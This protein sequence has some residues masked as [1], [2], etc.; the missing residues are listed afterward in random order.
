MAPTGKSTVNLPTWI[1]LD[2]AKFKKLSVTASLPGTGL[3]ATTTAE[4]VSL[5]IEPGT[6]DAQTY[7]P[8]GECAINA[9]GSIGAPYAKGK[10]DQI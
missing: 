8:S 9:Y 1:W 3:S 7:P 4:P 2:K 10:A 6:A 5:H